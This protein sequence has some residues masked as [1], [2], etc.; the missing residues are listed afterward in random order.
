M[1]RALSTNE[2]KALAACAHDRWQN[3]AVA[4]IFHGAPKWQLPAAMA[5]IHGLRPDLG[6]EPDVAAHHVHMF[7][8]PRDAAYFDRV[9]RLMKFF[10][11]GT[12]WGE[13]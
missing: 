6:V 2:I 12:H 4:R 1:T 5:A 10:N 13:G 3:E 7:R 9:C 8:W 11:I